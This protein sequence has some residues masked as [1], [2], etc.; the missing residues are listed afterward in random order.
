[1]PEQGG[2]QELSAPA[3]EFAAVEYLNPRFPPPLSFPFS[4]FS[5]ALFAFWLRSSVVSV[6][7]SLISES[8]LRSTIVIILI[9]VFGRTALW[10]CPRST[11]TVSSVSHCLRVTRTHVFHYVLRLAWDVRKKPLG[12]QPQFTAN[13]RSVLFDGRGVQAV[14]ML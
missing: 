11:S 5:P 9:F 6:L 12:P 14:R 7:F 4:L 2:G 3:A 13:C 8:T 1:M 10:A